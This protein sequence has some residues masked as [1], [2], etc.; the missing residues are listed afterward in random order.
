MLPEEFAKRFKLLGSEPAIA[1]GC[2]GWHP[3]LERKTGDLGIGPCWRGCRIP[4]AHK[5]VQVDAGVQSGARYR[6]AV[7][8]SFWPPLHIAQNLWGPLRVFAQVHQR[9][10]QRQFMSVDGQ[11]ETRG[12]HLLL[13][14]LEDEAAKQ[15][16]RSGPAFGPLL[17]RFVCKVPVVRHALA[18]HQR[19]AALG[20]QAPALGAPLHLADE[21]NFARCILGDEQLA[22]GV[23][24]RRLA[25][26]RGPS[27]A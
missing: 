27:P 9:T 4:E 10:R 24:S 22:H 1:Q 3:D 23:F 25:L 15:V 17:R 6:L 11:G 14:Q 7:V 8:Q 5:N 12:R 13:Q 20:T 26:R 19:A 2:G 16:Q 18:G 21:P